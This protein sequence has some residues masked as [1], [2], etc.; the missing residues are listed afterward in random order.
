MRD[1]GVLTLENIAP[2]LFIAVINLN[3]GTAINTL[4]TDKLYSMDIS[5]WTLEI[6]I[7]YFAMKYE[8]KPRDYGKK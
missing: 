2:Y 7:K 4:L 6:A 8:I 1:A 5:I 3:Y